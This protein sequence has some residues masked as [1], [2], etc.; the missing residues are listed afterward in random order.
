MALMFLSAWPWPLRAPILVLCA[1]ATAVQAAPLKLAYYDE[2]SATF[3]TRLAAARWINANVSKSDAICLT[4]RELVP[5]EVPPFRFDRYKINSPGCR[6]LVRVERYPASVRVEP[7]LS[8]AMRFTPRFS[9][10]SFP[11]VWGHINP[12]ITIYRKHD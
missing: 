8:I 9:P 4:T 11:L 5:F 1:A 12:Q 7:D 6:W 3:S 2:N 10:Q